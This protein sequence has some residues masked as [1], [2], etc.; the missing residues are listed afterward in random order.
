[1]FA[2]SAGAAL[3]MVLLAACGD[4]QTTDTRGYTKAP[5]EHPS[6]L[7][8]GEEPGE[9]AQYGTPNRVVAEELR[10]P[11][12]VQVAQTDTGGAAAPV[13]LPEGGTQYMAVEGQEVFGGPGVCF[14][15]H[16]S[17]GVCGPLSPA[18][19]DAEWL[20]IDGSY[21]AIVWIVTECVPAPQQFPAPMPA[22]GGAPLTDDQVRQVAAYV[23]SISR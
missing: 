17:N 19:N 15:C 14:V 6:L 21:D 20:N 2:R 22:R 23:Y 16:G 9:M 5:L 18:L 10:L 1:R 3:G 12:D 13:K 7:I 11:E 8:G 4:P